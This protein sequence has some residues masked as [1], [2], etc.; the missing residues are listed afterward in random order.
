MKLPTS[1]RHPAALVPLLLVAVLVL[2]PLVARHLEQ[3]FYLVLAT[4]FIVYA[5]AA[6]AL[7]LALG[8]GGMV[9]FGH[10]LFFGMGAYSVAIPAHFGM[11]NGWLHLS[12]CIASCAAVG[13]LTGAISLRTSG[14]AFIMITLAFAQMGYFMFVSLKQLG[15]DD[16]T[17]IASGSHFFGLDLGKAENL[18]VVALAV[19]LLCTWWMAR[20][21]VS[22]FG[23]TLRAANRNARKVNAAGLDARRYQL[24][25]YVL[26]AVLCGI[27]GML[28]ANLN[29]F[30]TPNF[31]TWMVSGELI[32]MVVLGGIGTVFGPVFGAFAFLGLEE[33]LK[34]LTA[35]WMAPFGLAIVAIA[36]LGKN[37][38]AGL[39]AAWSRRPAWRM[40]RFKRALA[41]QATKE[42]VR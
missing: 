25:A 21:R 31:L 42:G 33:I 1:W 27:A 20:L 16:G 28:M 30:A 14:M 18:Y 39:L 8:L 15:G 36:L 26:S 9:S 4:R 29:A 6:I 23:M 35:H 13:A 38:I 32:V 19:L 37:G 24:A 17:P 5:I 12:V 34:E 22:P 3:N 2:L 40:P 11:A 10:A 41:L 7:N